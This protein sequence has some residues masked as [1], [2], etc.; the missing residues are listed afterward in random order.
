[1]STIRKIHTQ[2]RKSFC[3]YT[4]LIVALYTSLQL[5]HFHL[6]NVISCRIVA[7]KSLLGHFYGSHL[8][9]RS[10][11]SLAETKFIDYD[12]SYNRGL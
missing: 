9:F 10:W 4:V 3:L 12:T 5:I 1:M 6:P 11:F 2:L 7:N 8:Q